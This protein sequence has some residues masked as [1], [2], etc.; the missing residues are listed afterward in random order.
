MKKAFK[1]RDFLTLQEFSPEEIWKILKLS[2]FLKKGGKPP[3]KLK[4]KILA[5]IF[6]KPSTR[7]RVS[8]EVAMKQ[9]G[10]EAL[11]LSWNELQLGRGET[12]A[13][14]ARVLSR[15]VNGIM[16]RVYAQSDLEELAEYASIPVIN[17]LS[18]LCHPIQ[19]LADLFTIWEKKGKI[20]NLKVA[21]IGDGNNVCN[22][23]LIGCS[24]IGI[25]LSVACPEG[26]EPN[27]KFVS[28]ALENAAK[29][30]SKIEILKEPFKA[31]ENAD[32]IYTDVIVSMG[33][34]SER[35]KKLKVFIPKYQVTTE[36]LK[37]ANKNVYFMHPLP[38][39]RGEEVT[40]DVIDG[41]NSIVWDQ[42]ENR[43]H[44]TKALLSL[45]L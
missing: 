42:A 29:S 20:K 39:H 24:K 12:I 45:I 17:G 13:D 31:V 9:L 7:T 40:S 14:T 43:L 5:M 28:L 16:A 4:G 32:F 22:S 11:Y 1:G 21:Y 15:Y 23:L 8:F 41:P 33:Q 19:T 27:E 38:C 25:N 30:G 44:T 35:E 10:G 37:L 18:D 6:Q 3:T 26:Y 34:E 36:L 2:N